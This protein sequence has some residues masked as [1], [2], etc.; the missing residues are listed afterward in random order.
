MNHIC[1]KRNSYRLIESKFNDDVHTQNG[2]VSYGIA[3]E[4]EPM[5]CVPD[6]STDINFVKKLIKK[7]NDGNLSAI[8]LKDVIE[9]SIR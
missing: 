2:G 1:Q 8:H 3:S 9:D 7:C 4:T 6:I 5:F